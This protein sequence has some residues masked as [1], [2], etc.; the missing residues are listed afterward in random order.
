MEIKK[1]SRCKEKWDISKQKVPLYDEDYV[2]Q[3]SKL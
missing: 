2:Y 3:A 1:I